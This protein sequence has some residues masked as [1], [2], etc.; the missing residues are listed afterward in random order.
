MRNT[1][2]WTGAIVLSLLAHAGTA[3]LFEPDET[4]PEMALIAGGEEM[5]VTVLGNAFEEAL[6]AGDPDEEITPAEI[7]P[8]EVEPEPVEVAQVAPVQPEVTAETPSEVVPTEADVILPADEIP[9]IATEEPEVTA[10]VAPAETVIPEEKPEPEKV[11]KPDPEKKVEPKKKPEKK[12]PVRKMAGESG[13]EKESANKGQADGVENAVA[14]SA[15]GKKGTRAQQSGNAV[16]SNYK[17][18]VQAKLNRVRRSSPR[19][20]GESLRGA[21]TVRFVVAASGAVSSISVVRSSGS[22]TLDETALDTVRRA[23]PF[24]KIPESEGV[25]SWP[26]VI[27]IVFAR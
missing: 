25:A 10:T 12:K 8:E 6:Q 17:G 27:P 16:S 15:T 20:N 22:P 9:P 24:P 18:K 2:K 26:F 14:S 11:E 3:K 19:V 5:E 4:P 23:A 7:Q 21:V 13:K 1:I